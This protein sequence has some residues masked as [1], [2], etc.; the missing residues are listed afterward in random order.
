MNYI[1]Q[2]RKNVTL[3]LDVVVVMPLREAPWLDQSEATLFLINV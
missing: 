2:V 1:V 3:R